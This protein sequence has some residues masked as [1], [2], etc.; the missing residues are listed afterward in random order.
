[1]HSLQELMGTEI[2]NLIYIHY[3]ENGE[4]IDDYEDVLLCED[5]DIDESRIEPLIKILVHYYSY[6]KR[7]VA[8]V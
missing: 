4:Y 3:D 7:E 5:S 6:S 8:F 2:Y 1:M